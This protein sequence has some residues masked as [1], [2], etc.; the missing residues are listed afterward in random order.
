MAG[1]RVR[2]YEPHEYILWQG[3]P[4][5]AYV[6]V[7]QQGSVSLWDESGAK[8][9]LRDIRGAGDLLG[10][11]RYSGARSCLHS[12]RS[13]SDTVLYGF[14]ADDFETHVLKYPQAAQYVMAEGRV[15]A[16]YQAAGG[17]RDPR[18]LFL[19]DVVG[20]RPA[21]TCSATDT[22]AHAARRLLDSRS[23]A[24]AVV[25][26][27][28]RALAVLTA[29]PF[30]AWVAAG[31]GD[32]QA[33]VTSL[34]LNA[35]VCLG[36][37]ATV[38]DGVLAMGSAN[39]DALVVTADGTSDGALQVLCTARDMT[40]VFGD[41]PTMLLREIRG[42]STLQELRTL[43]RRARAFTLDALTGAASVE[44]LA[45]LAHLI[46]A[47]IVTR[48]LAVT[49]AE[50]GPG[51]WCF[52][53]SSGRAESLTLQ[54]PSLLLILDAD[55]QRTQ[56]R[57]AYDR[58]VEA[59]RE[60]D[61]LPGL[62]VPFD[63]AFHVASV[64]EWQ[65]RY[66]AWITDPVMQQTYRARALFDLRPVHGNQTLWRDL[67]AV[68]MNTVD[69]DFVHVLANDCL[70]NLPPLTFF[71]DDVVDRV[72]EHSAVFRLEHSA[73]L[74][75]VDVGRVFGMA[76]R[77]VM[78]RTTLER[79][80][81]A[82]GLLPEHEAIFRDASETLRVVLW[83]QARVGIS[84]GTAGFELPPALLSRYDRQVLKGGFRSIL[85]LLEF[86]ADREWIRR[87]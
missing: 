3:E 11:E 20:R 13:E 14:P 82:R 35:P 22:I 17:R 32:A 60:C 63:A 51:C 19:H 87:V 81:T 74:P 42:A 28:H 68:V 9:E 25:D 78:G 34:T 48:I 79:L 54:S 72:G 29:A 15:T 62:D 31:G 30:L 50:R 23:E 56:A 43:N 18:Q 58:A 2:F 80:A 10:I 55:Q 69:Q 76:A 61:Y 67:E 5:K 46:D 52:G 39:A 57:A 6:F 53:G 73:L 4:H 37:D 59:L 40:T 36:V 66:R 41:Q 26:T 1:G 77:K 75:L 83:Q 85:R 44:W 24:I 7:I 47:A 64:D 12:A 16:D 84:Q 8:A 45:R 33:P 49:G 21:P 70:N 27:Q 38:A 65:V 86:T 71:K